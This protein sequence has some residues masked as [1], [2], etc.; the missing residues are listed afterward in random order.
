MSRLALFLFGPPRI[1]R[2]GEPVK[3]DR[4]KA[5]ALLAYLALSST[6]QR[7]DTLAALFWPELDQTHARRALRKTLWALQKALGAE[8]FEIGRE[9]LALKR[10]AGFWLDV[11]HF[12]DLLALCRAHGHAADEACPACLVS[13]AEAVALWGE[14]GATA[15][16]VVFMSGFSLR[17]SPG[18]DEWQ[19]FQNE[20]LRCELG[21]ALERLARAHG[22][23]GAFEPALVY[24]RCWQALDPCHEP[25]QRLLMQLYAQAGQRAEALRQYRECV[26]MLEAELGVPPQQETTR[27]SQAIQENRLAP[28]LIPPSN[29]PAQ[30][31]P[32]IG[33]AEE[34]AEIDRLL[35]EPAGRLLSLIGPGGV[36]KTRLALQAAAGQVRAFSHGVYFVPLSSVDAL[37]PAIVKTLELFVHDGAE[38]WVQL[39]D[40]VRRKEMLLVLDNF[41]HLL[42]PP[43]SPPAGGEAQGGQNCWPASWRSPRP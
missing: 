17:D 39:L 13:L 18:F 41:E 14:T 2:E 1:E 5:V 21:G 38:P 9:S 24:A 36:G 16:A 26:R 4:H 12:H 37:A 20:G 27:L 25:A 15:L 30:P 19:L 29:L 35:K 7:R 6:S 8:W 40:Y 32:F 3:L 31:T 23:R 28:P 43:L 22:A 34:L 33:R 10:E 11:D 42:A